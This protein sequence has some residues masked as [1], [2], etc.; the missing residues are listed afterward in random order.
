VSTSDRGRSIVVS[1]LTSVLWRPPAVFGPLVLVAV[2]WALA[3]GGSNAAKTL[4]QIYVAEAVVGSALALFVSL[5][6]CLA[7]IRTAEWRLLM[8]LVV[9]LR[10]LLMSQ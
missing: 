2:A 7:I 5:K 6:P 1:A 4:D 9:F 8:G 3:K 10:F